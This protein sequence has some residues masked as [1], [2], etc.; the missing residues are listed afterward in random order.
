MW[1]VVLGLWTVEWCSHTDGR[2]PG[3]ASSSPGEI[4]VVA[5]RDVFIQLSIMH[6]E[7]LVIMDEEEETTEKE[8]K[9]FKA[10]GGW[11]PTHMLHR[12]KPSHVHISTY[13]HFP[14]HSHFLSTLPPPFPE[15]PT[16]SPPPPAS[17]LTGGLPRAGRLL[18]WIPTSAGPCGVAKSRISPVL[19]GAAAGWS[20]SLL[21]LV[22]MTIWWS[23]PRS[24]LPEFSKVSKSANR[25]SDVCPVI[26][27]SDIAVRHRAVSLHWALGA[28][29]HKLICCSL[30]VSAAT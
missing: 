4:Q 18:S 7:Y 6:H 17:L 11:T 10:T 25:S 29:G 3:P 23:S 21:G 9:C 16:P 5:E 30:A 20:P 8:V 28:L 27:V 15:A 13:P 22:M 26:R 2:Y 24:I 14:Y 1:R 19:V 12:E